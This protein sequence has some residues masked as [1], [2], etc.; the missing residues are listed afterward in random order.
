MTVVKP[1]RISR[2]PFASAGVDRRCHKCSAFC[3]AN[4]QGSVDRGVI[5][6]LGPAAVAPRAD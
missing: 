3:Q 2:K 6:I 4:F 1:S 5:D